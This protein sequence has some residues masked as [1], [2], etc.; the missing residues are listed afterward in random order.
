MPR[1]LVM[2]ERVVHRLDRAGY[3]SALAVR[4]ERAA[5]ASA[6]FWVFERQELDGHF[7]EFIEAA[8]QESL[9]SAIDQIAEYEELTPPVVWK[10]VSGL[11]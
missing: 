11:N 3:L 7:L 1:L 6:N 8:S 10:E 4:R 2:S 5:A 9:E